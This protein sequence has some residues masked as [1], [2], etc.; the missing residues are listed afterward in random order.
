VADRHGATAA[1][2][3]CVGWRVADGRQDIDHRP[4][5]RVASGSPAMLPRSRARKSAGVMTVTVSSEASSRFGWRA[6]PIGLLLRPLKPRDLLRRRSRGRMRGQTSSP[7]KSAL[8]SK[9]SG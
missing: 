2:H 3:G 7:S 5:R 4:N 1:A 6:L 8:P 9:L